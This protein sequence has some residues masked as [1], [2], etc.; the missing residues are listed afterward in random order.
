[1][2]AGLSFGKCDKFD[3]TCVRLDHHVV[4]GRGEHV[5]L[6]GAHMLLFCSA[7]SSNPTAVPRKA[8]HIFVTVQLF[9]PHSLKGS[10]PQ[11]NRNTA[12]NLAA[13]DQ[14]THADQ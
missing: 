1:M 6:E 3:C 8:Q 10:L 7:H 14:S 11:I 13:A 2:G 12:L 5:R 4:V 9:Q